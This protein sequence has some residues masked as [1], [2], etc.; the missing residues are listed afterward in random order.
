[1]V[2]TG[3]SHM[4]ARGEGWLYRFGKEQMGRGL[5]PITGPRRFPLAFLFN[6]FCVLQFLLFYFLFFLISFI[7]FAFDTQMTSNQKQK[8]SKIKINI[9][10]QYQTCFHNQ[11]KILI[12]G[13]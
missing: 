3:G 11:N 2:L 4:S 10:K 6:Y 8:F 12:K 7:T 13:S 5:I 9:L 1:M